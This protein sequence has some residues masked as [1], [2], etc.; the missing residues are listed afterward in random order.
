MKKTIPHTPQQNGVTEMMNKMIIE[1]A[2]SMRL[3]VE[4]T[5]QF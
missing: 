5:K 3:H 4:L 1:G 2:K